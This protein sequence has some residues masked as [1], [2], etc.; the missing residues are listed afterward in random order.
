LSSFRAFEMREDLVSGLGDWSALAAAEG[1]LEL[2]VRLSAAV[3]AA[4]ERLALWRPPRSAHRWV[5]HVD[6][7]RASMTA[8]EFDAARTEGKGWDIDEA[9]RR[10][11]SGAVAST[12]SD[13]ESGED[14]EAFALSDADER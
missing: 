12:G 13:R 14:Q 1:R 4:S 11:Q 9:L 2:A 7:L 3:D 8:D 10:A 6:S 5:A